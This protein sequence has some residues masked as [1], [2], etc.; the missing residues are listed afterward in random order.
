MSPIGHSLGMRSKVHP[1]YQMKYRTGFAAQY[2]NPQESILRFDFKLDLRRLEIV[3][4]DAVECGS[5][6]SLAMD[7]MT[8]AG[9]LTPM[10]SLGSEPRAQSFEDAHRAPLA[11]RPIRRPALTAITALTSLLIFVGLEVQAGII[12]DSSYRELE[13]EYFIEYAPSPPPTTFPN[14]SLGVWD[15]E[16]FDGYGGFARQDTMVGNERI[17]G[18]L[19]SL[20]QGGPGGPDLDIASAKTNLEVVF[21]VDAAETWNFSAIYPDLFT[22][23]KSGS[24]SLYA[25]GIY[26]DPFPP[27][28]E[29]DGYWNFDIDVQ[30]Q[31][32]V[33]YRLYA[34]GSSQ[35]NWNGGSSVFD[36][37]AIPEPG[38]GLLIG[39]GLVLT[40]AMRR[41]RAGTAS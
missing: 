38:T 35:N 9:D 23:D 8:K 32:G 31:P 5:G 17:G 39:L 40:G 2:R 11:S 29:L 27:D 19:S 21:H 15:V 1:K 33:S 37:Q 7:R 25:D 6:T 36:F 26:I 13:F 16:E 41:R 20:A 34:S 14:S 3:E 12:I 18:E 22:H 10:T 4:S 24:A 30:L 28:Y